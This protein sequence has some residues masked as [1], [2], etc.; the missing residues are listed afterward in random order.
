LEVEVEHSLV[1]EES[2]ET[3]TDSANGL[4]VKK[5]ESQMMGHEGE[6]DSLMTR[7]PL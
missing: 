5:T 7:E 4:K 2:K 3:R 1:N 6:R